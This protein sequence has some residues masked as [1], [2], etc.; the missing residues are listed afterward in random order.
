[1]FMI[2][3][4][5]YYLCLN[6]GVEKSTWK[7]EFIQ[8]V[9]PRFSRPTKP[10]PNTGSSFLPSS[11]IF[12]SEKCKFISRFYSAIDFSVFCYLETSMPKLARCPCRPSS[13]TSLLQ[14]Q[15]YIEAIPSAVIVPVFTTRGWAV[16]WKCSIAWLLPPVPSQFLRP[17]A[18]C[19][20]ARQSQRLFERSHS[21]QCARS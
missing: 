18:R 13:T 12:D 3:D 9:L 6:S 20:Q 4:P 8:H 17:H 11:R 14:A 21:P 16:F 2:L 1:M 10:G 5:P 19:P 15:H 7:V